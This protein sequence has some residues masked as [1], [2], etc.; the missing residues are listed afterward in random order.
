M[1]EGASRTWLTVTHS[2][3]KREVAKG[4]SRAGYWLCGS[5]GTDIPKRAR[6][7]LVVVCTC[8]I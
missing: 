4:A 2:F 1:V 8:W 6:V 5:G 3:S 7:T